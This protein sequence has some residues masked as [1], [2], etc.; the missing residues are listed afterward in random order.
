MINLLFV[1]L[2]TASLDETATAFAKGDASA[3]EDLLKAGIT[4]I[5]PLRKVRAQAPDAVDPL[6]FEIKTR[7]EDRPAK[8]LLDALEAKHSMDTAGAV[9]FEVVL[10]ELCGLFSLTFDPALFR[11]HW[12]KNVTI[13][14]KDRSR[15]ECLESLCRQLGLDYGFFYGTV[16]IAAPDRLWPAYVPPPRATPLTADESA[17]AAKLIERLA[18]DDFQEREE[19]QAV[20]KKLGKG[21]MPLLEK[22]AQGDDAERRA[23]CAALLKVLTDPPPQATFH[24]PAAAGQK[25]AGADDGLRKQLLSE[26]VSFKVQDI[27][28]D[29]AMRLMLQP[30]QIPCRLALSAQQVRLTLDAQNHT[31][32]ALISIATHFCG[33]DFLIQDGKIVIDTREEIQRRLSE[34]R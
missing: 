24:R 14:L 31:A 7:V 10:G 4:A 1:L 13:K 21:A 28:L 33:H 17:R 20:L 11:T 9:G 12:G 6:I 3:R 5:L 8:D 34:G 25:L 27:V 26:W 19:A 23:R 2:Q 18:S 15:R 22:G 30:R 32:W 29:G 16:L